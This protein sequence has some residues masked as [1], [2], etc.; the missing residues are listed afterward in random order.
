MILSKA[1]HINAEYEQRE[2]VRDTLLR[3]VTVLLALLIP[4]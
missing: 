1:P 3:V 4:L 2:E